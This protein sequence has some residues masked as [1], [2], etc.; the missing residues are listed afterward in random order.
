MLQPQQLDDFAFRQIVTLPQR[1]IRS[2]GYRPGVAHS[3]GSMRVAR[4]VQPGSPI[5]IRFISPRSETRVFSLMLETDKVD[6]FIVGLTELSETIRTAR[7]SFT[8]P[9]PTRISV[10]PSSR[11]CQPRARMIDM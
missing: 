1:T 4:Q 9:Q 11:L 8:P 2:E 3:I 7:D 6:D 10:R 5:L